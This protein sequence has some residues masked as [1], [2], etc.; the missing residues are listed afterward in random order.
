MRLYSDLDET[1][2]GNVVNENGQIERIIPRPHAQ[3]FIKTLASQGDLW[4]LTLGTRDHAEDAMRVLRPASRLFRGMI[5]REDMVPVE[6]QLLV[7]FDTPG[8]TMFDQETLL[9]EVKPIAPPGIVFD[10]YSFGSAIGLLKSKSVGIDS[11]HWIRVEAFGPGKPDRDGLK[12]GYEKYSQRFPA[13]VMM[14][15]R[16]VRYA[17]SWR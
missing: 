7:I 15:R 2:I 10:D 5:T 9:N 6:D 3:W 17:G 14:G 13:A 8:L 4:L 16:K 11:Q 12:K 1:L